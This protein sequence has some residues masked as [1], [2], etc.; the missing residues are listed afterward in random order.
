M[1]LLPQRGTTLRIHIDLSVDR[2]VA[3]HRQRERF[4]RRFP[5]AVATLWL[6]FVAIS[7]SV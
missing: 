3:F 5:F 2:K 4:R 7:V 1:S 6:L